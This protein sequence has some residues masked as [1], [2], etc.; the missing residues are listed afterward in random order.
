MDFS[1]FVFHFSLNYKLLSATDDD[2]L[3]GVADTDTLEVVCSRIV[4]CYLF[5]V[6]CLYTIGI[7]GH[8]LAGIDDLAGV[9]VTGIIMAE[10]RHDEDM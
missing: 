9:C 6:N 3:V 8:A 1:L 2:A 7:G 4:H 10:E 5:I